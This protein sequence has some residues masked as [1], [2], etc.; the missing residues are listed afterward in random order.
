[1]TIRSRLTLWFTGIVSVL[2]LVFC[3]V[4]YVVAG[5]LRQREFRDRLRE[6]ALTSVKLLYGRQA[7]NLELFKLLDLNHMTVLNDEEIIIYDDTDQIRYESG[8]D[9]L[10]VNKATLDRVRR[11]KEIFWR[12]GDREIVGTL[13]ANQQSRFVVFSSGVDKYGFT[14]QR[15]FTRIL[16]IGW[17]VA[18]L[19]TLAAGWFFAGRSL[20]P[21]RRVIGRID[22]ITATNLDQ[23]LPTSADE[24]EI[25]QLSTRFNQMLDRLQ[26]A[27]QT[28]QAFVSHASHELR[29]PLTAIS[30]Q[31]EVSLMTEDDPAELKETITS[32]L[33]DVRGLAKLT[34]GLLSLAKV[35]VDASALRMA[36]FALDELLWKVRAEVLRLHPDHQVVVMLDDVPGK[37]LSWQLTGNESLLST[38]L[39]N[40]LENGGKFSP[41][42]R[43]VVH[44]GQHLNLFIIRVHNQGKPIRTE[45]LPQLF[46]PFW[47]G[48]N[49]QGIAGHGVGLSLAHR[50]VQLHKGRIEV[51]SKEGFGTLFTLSLPQ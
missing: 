11:E 26:K 49:A 36:P 6:E 50:I 29:T 13:F 8:T 5:E 14:K 25:D 21:L 35:G 48:S 47:R 3:L 38:V 15:N 44:L 20:Y 33:D 22:G 17:L 2:L 9:Y 19:A 18:T 28:Q 46:D 16:Q 23:R 40:L 1:M 37:M 39:L 7:I 10:D 4:L 51:E 27:F 32:V 45:E 43:V 24:D 42:H 41:D 34:N 30:G 31:L 12:E